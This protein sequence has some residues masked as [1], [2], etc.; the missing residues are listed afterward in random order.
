MG[1]TS[2]RLI[3]KTPCCSEN[4]LWNLTFLGSADIQLS[5]KGFYTYAKPG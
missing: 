5:D 3:I 2:L 4:T 1:H